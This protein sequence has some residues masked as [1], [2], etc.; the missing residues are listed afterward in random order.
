MTRQELQE[1]FKPTLLRIRDVANLKYKEA[2]RQYTTLIAQ[3][4][5]NQIRSKNVTQTQINKIKTIIAQAK[6]TPNIT[7]TALSCL[8]NQEYVANRLS[9]SALNYCQSS[10]NN[11]LLTNSKNRFST[12]GSVAYN[13][14]SWCGSLNPLSTQIQSY[15]KCL[16]DKIY[17]LNL[18]INL[19]QREYQEL[20]NGTLHYNLN[21]LTDKAGGIISQIGVISYEINVCLFT[22]L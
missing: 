12:V 3:I 21:C 17:D 8:Q 14:I 18:Q 4:N 20:S 13:T 6:K 7:S 22:P 15:E 5:N 2:N 1:E 16:S 10:A 9:T 19:V 11:S